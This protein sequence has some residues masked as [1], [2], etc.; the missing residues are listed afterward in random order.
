MQ[1]ITSAQARGVLF[2]RQSGIFK[3]NPSAELLRARESSVYARTSAYM[4]ITVLLLLLLLLLFYVSARHIFCVIFVLFKHSND[5][6]R[7]FEPIFT[8]FSITVPPHLPWSL[9][10]QTSYNNQLCSDFLR[11]SD[12]FG[13][14]QPWG[15]PT[16]HTLASLTGERPKLSH[17]S[18]TTGLWKLSTGISPFASPSLSITLPS[19]LYSP[20]HSLLAL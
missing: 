4:I 16:T 8:V 19:L 6:T 17:I 15:S 2:S 1:L 3:Q 20:S 14:P 18:P 7:F 9:T 5:V 10:F 11:P 12:N 13:F